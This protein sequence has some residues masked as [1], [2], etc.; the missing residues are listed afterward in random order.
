[1]WTNFY[2]RIDLVDVQLEFLQSREIPD[3]PGSVTRSLARFDIQC[4]EFSF[5]SHSNQTRTINL[6]SQAVIGY[7]TRYEGEEDNKIIKHIYYS[8]S[9]QAMMLIINLT[10]LQRCCDLAATQGGN[11]LLFRRRFTSILA[12][13]RSRH[14]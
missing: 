11:G 3:Q 4:S 2:F 10:C 5:I 1:M 6:V 7:D 13:R 14:P 12:P 8:I 9:L